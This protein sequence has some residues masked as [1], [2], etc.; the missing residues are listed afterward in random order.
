MLSLNNF[1]FGKIEEKN[2]LQH[3]SHSH[4]LWFSTYVSATGWGRPRDQPRRRRVA[5]RCMPPHSLTTLNTHQFYL[6]HLHRTYGTYADPRSVSKG[7][8]TA[9]QN[10]VSLGP[11]GTAGEAGCHATSFLSTESQ[12]NPVRL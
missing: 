12:C 10:Y 11:C 1:G 3:K 9:G 7:N 6:N 8:Q 5:V 4:S 2:R